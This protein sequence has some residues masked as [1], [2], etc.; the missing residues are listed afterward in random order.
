[1]LSS[2]LLLKKFTDTFVNFYGGNNT[3][4]CTDTRRMDRC[5][6][7]VII[8]NHVH[9][10]KVRVWPDKSV[11]FPEQELLSEKEFVFLTQTTTSNFDQSL[12]KYSRS[13][14]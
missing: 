14:K 3:S 6:R 7:I 10:L 12:N 2:L 13:V 5:R 9:Y 4:N 1:M 8:M 11:K